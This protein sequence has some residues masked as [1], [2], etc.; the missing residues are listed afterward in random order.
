MPAGWDAVG[1]FRVRI[2]DDCQ[3]RSV[4]GLCAG[5]LALSATGGLLPPCPAAQVVRGER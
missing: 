2:A 5:P 4:Y 3:V 1:C